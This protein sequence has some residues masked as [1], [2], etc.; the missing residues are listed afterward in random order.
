M[1]LLYQQIRK[2][3]YIDFTMK[4]STKNVS[5]KAIYD[6]ILGEF[7]DKETESIKELQ[8]FPKEGTVTRYLTES[9]DFFKKY[10]DVVK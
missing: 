8:T 2:V 4:N 6:Y 1:N 9:F 5:S 10:V 3:E 7:L